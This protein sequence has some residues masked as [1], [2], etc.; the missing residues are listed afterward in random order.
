MAVAYACLTWLFPGGWWVKRLLHWKHPQ[1]LH[2]HQIVP[3]WSS[4][5]LLAVIGMLGDLAESLVKRECDA[6]DSGHL[7]PGLGGVWM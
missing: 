4:G 6:K 3:P 2:C 1:L 5:A 7:L